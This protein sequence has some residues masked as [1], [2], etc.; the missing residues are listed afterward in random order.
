MLLMVE[1]KRVRM[2]VDVPAGLPERL[3]AY[4]KRRGKIQKDLLARILTRFFEVPDPV[5]RAWENDVDEGME[6][7]YAAALETLAKD[8]RERA[9]LAKYKTGAES[10]DANKPLDPAPAPAAKTKKG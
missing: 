5:K 2:G 9:R 6:L 8:L 10:E 7:P 1:D 4:C 3:R